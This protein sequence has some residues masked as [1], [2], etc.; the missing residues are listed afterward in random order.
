MSS[1]IQAIIF[2]FG[3]VLINWDPHKLFNKYFSNDSQAIDN[4]LTE[5]N[6]LAWNLSMDAGYP[7]TRVVQ[8]LSAQFPQYAHLIRAYD[9]EW[10]DTITWVIPEIVE[11]L[12]ELKTA[13]YN[14][15]VLQICLWK[16]SPL[17]N[18]NMRLSIYSKVFLFLEK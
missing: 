6:F 10:G 8:E 14:S 3:G 11:I 18:T 2:D 17:S 4:F 15:T 13:G 16:N 9:Q 7:F 1:S 12:H 5:I